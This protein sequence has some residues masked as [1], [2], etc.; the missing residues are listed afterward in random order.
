MKYISIDPSSKNPAYAYGDTKIPKHFGQMPLY[1][2]DRQ[3]L[4]NWRQLFKG[5]ATLI[6]ENQ[7]LARHKDKQGKITIN[8]K[9]LMTLSESVGLLKGLAVESGIMKIIPVAAKTW[10]ASMLNGARMKRPQLKALSKIR[11]SETVGE[12]I[13][14]DDIADAINIY[15]FVFLYGLV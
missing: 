14:S 7:Y 11:A 13:E 12:E 10:Q 5:N 9:S 8:V 15:N 3:S 4:A 1:R 6:I 2:N